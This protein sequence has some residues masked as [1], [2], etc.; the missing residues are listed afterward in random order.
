MAAPVATVRLETAHASAVLA[1][2][3]QVTD[4]RERSR[5]SVMAFH[6]VVRAPNGS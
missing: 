6:A 3:C 5:I 2:A 1:R 4:W